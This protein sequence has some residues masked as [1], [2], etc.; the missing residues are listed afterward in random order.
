[1][2]KKI[3]ALFDGNVFHPEELPELI[4]DHYYTITIHLEEE[5]NIEKNKTFMKILQRATDLGI[6][7]LARNHDHYIYGTEK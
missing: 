4:P 6:K 3:K 1:M 5:K 2:S 7:D